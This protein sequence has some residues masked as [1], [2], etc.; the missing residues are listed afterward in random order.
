MH[1]GYMKVTLYLF[2]WPRIF[3]FSYKIIRYNILSTCTPYPA[4]PVRKITRFVYDK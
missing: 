3:L 1:M 4:S 2:V